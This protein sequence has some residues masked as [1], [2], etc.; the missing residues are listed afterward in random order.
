MLLSLIKQSN[1]KRT[2]PSTLADIDIQM[3]STTKVPAVSFCRDWY[4]V[5]KE[6]SNSSRTNC[7]L[8]FFSQSFEENL[9]NDKTVVMRK[10]LNFKKPLEIKIF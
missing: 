1:R 9:I 4:P 3:D 5:F 10:T 8:K 6:L 2:I 7:T